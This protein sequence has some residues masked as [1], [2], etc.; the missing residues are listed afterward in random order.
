MS[1]AEAAIVKTAYKAGKR[2]SEQNLRMAEGVLRRA[3][4]GNIDYKRKNERQQ[5]ND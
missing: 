1:P 3:R 5:R 2:V 4:E